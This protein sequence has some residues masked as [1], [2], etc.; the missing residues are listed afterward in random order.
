MPF[1]NWAV[2][3]VPLF[4][5]LDPA[6]PRMEIRPVLCKKS[7]CDLAVRVLTPLCPDLQQ[8]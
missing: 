1:S 2:F 7:I 8:L 5:R 6:C 3:M 4:S